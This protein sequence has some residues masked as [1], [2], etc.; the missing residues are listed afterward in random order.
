MK[1]HLNIYY[2]WVKGSN[3]SCIKYKW[4]WY[5]TSFSDLLKGTH[6][7]A[8]V[9]DEMGRAMK[10]ALTGVSKLLS[11]VFSALQDKMMQRQKDFFFAYRFLQLNFINH[12]GEGWTVFSKA[13]RWCKFVLLTQSSYLSILHQMS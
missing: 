2:G 5:L 4:E 10:R 12:R 9:R 13:N 11:V 7:I 3:H 6:T 1:T 8:S